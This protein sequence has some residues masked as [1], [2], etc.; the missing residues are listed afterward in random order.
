MFLTGTRADYGKIKLIAKHLADDPGFEVF[1]FT[2]GMHLL[3]KYGTTAKAVLREFQNV[4]LYNNQPVAAGMDI[5]L[6]NTIYGFSNYVSDIKPDMVIVHGDRPETL[7]GA[8]VGSF[9]NILVSH[10]EG[11]EVSGTIDELIRHSVSKL[12]HVHFVSNLNARD[13][14]IQMGELED[15]I[16][17]IGS[18]DID[19]MYSNTLPN[20]NNVLR[21]YDIPF[22]SYGI[23]VYHPVTTEISNLDQAAEE[24]VD[25]L[26]KSGQ[27]YIVIS[28]NNDLGGDIIESNLV[29]LERNDRFKIF[30]SIEFESFLTLLKN[31]RFVI[32]NSSMG[33]REAPAY[34]K[35]AINVGS[36]QKNRSESNLVYTVE[37]KCG[38]IVEA[39]E[40][41]ISNDPPVAT[42]NEF[43]DGNSAKRFVD[44]L[45]DGRIW[46]A[47]RQKQ[48]IPIGKI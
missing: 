29:V 11:G 44:V 31:C 47:S 32:G 38:A 15:N 22:K 16:F 20:L 39:I 36:R 6:S 35:W 41:A 23:A 37:D 12:S 21:H 28:P 24:Y 9:N 40:H 27:N 2:T 1:I 18:P 48:F 30:P 17:P 10:I 45:N 26:I 25:A 43:G 7:A 8:V 46:N 5:V 13:R 34:G 14:L 42:R 4:H 3:A 19:I 33:V